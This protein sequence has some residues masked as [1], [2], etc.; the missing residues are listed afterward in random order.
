MD[1]KERVEI[2]AATDTQLTFGRNTV[3]EL[4]DALDEA[5]KEKGKA[6]WCPECGCVAYVNKNLVGDGYRCCRDC[7]QDWWIDIEYSSIS[8]PRT[9]SVNKYIYGLVDEITAIKESFSRYKKDAQSANTRLREVLGKVKD[10]AE[11]GDEYGECN[12]YSIKIEANA[13]LTSDKPEET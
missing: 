11:G 9:D 7:G 4:L 8:P 2:R 12:Y 6:K 1:S 5:E 13:A 3:L 10:F